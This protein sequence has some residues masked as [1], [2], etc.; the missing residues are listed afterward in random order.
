MSKK[1]R[2][3]FEWLLIPPNVEWDCTGLYGAYMY[4]PSLEPCLALGTSWAQV[5]G[6][7]QAR[8]QKRKAW[9][10]FWFQDI[11]IPGGGT[12]GKYEWVLIKLFVA[13]SEN[14]LCGLKT[15]RYPAA[16]YQ[17]DWAKIKKEN[18]REKIEIKIFWSSEASR[19]FI[20][21]DIGICVWIA[22]GTITHK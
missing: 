22:W 14:N 2:Y 5:V 11:A 19:H 16:R 6:K 3:Q 1:N 8:A 21:R 17:I 13:D 12:Q 15:L 4:S 7:A 9:C 20:I 10:N 18:S